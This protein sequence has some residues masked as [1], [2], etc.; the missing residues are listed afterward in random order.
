VLRELLHDEVPVRNLRRIVELVLRYETADDDERP[1]ADLAA[2]VR[3][4]LADQIAFGPARGTAPIV[5]Y[6]IDASLEDA[7]V[8]T[9]GDTD[10]APADAMI[11]ALRAELL[12]LPQTA[13]WPALLTA[14]HVRRPM[15]D[16]VRDVFPQLTVLGYGD[17]PPARNIW[18]VARVYPV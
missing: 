1:A 5:V 2:F 6:L 10:D 9:A 11:A 14:D 16:V 4:G 15:R 7:L 12:T 13:S 8:A 17:V 18:P 3:S